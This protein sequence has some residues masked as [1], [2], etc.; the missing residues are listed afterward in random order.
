MCFFRGKLIIVSAYQGEIFTNRALGDEKAWIAHNVPQPSA[1][2]RSLMPFQ[3]R[4]DLLLI[5]G[6]GYLPP[7]NS[8]KVSASVI[9]LAD[10][11]K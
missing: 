9:N 10:L 11:L 4:P 1:Y 8:N 3:G 5:M 2:T 7:A 6:A